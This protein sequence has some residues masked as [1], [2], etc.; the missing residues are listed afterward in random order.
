MSEAVTD[1]DARIWH[2]RKDNS[3]LKS[4]SKIICSKY[5]ETIKTTRRE[6]EFT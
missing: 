6:I 1:S 4:I 5:K 3:P 2:L